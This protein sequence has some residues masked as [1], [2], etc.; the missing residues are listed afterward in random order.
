MQ[1]TRTASWLLYCVVL[2]GGAWLALTLRHNA[3][4]PVAAPVQA[5]TVDVSA[6]VGIDPASVKAVGLALTGDVELERDAAF[7]YI[8]A[9]QV[10]C[11][12]QTGHAVAKLATRVGLPTMRAAGKLLDK[13]PELA[14]TLY[15][16]I[17]GSADAAPCEAKRQQWLIGNYR[18]ALSPQAYV[19]GFPDSYFSPSI[20]SETTAR[21]FYRDI[22]NPCLQLAFRLLPLDPDVP[23]QCAS[24]RREARRQIVQS[25]C[26]AD[27]DTAEGQQHLTVD[28]HTLKSR[29][30]DMCQ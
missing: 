28:V 9:L 8:T 10:R 21:P 20:S 2:A 26:P 7:L 30:P 27:I 6:P 17:R 11:H 25:L 12:P 23:W 13:Q 14:H 5:T 3:A 4:A 16:V 29:M 19:D 15:Q 22:D 1:A 24:S 18:I